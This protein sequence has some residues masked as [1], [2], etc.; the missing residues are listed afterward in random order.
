MQIR[1]P[2]TWSDRDTKIDNVV[3]WTVTAE[4]PNGSKRIAAAV[5][6]FWTN[7]WVKLA[8]QIRDSASGLQPKLFERPILKMGQTLV[9]LPWVVGLQNNSTAA[10]NNLRRLGMR[11]GEVQKRNATNRGETW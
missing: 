2:L 1:F 10:I 9:Q 5:V 8:V 11:R 7:D 4:H 6:D 3:G